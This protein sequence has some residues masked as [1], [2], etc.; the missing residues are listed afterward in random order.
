M[1]WIDRIVASLLES[2]RKRKALDRINSIASFRDS[3]EVRLSEIKLICC[4]L[5]QG[6]EIKGYCGSFNYYDLKMKDKDR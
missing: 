1:N 4:Q 5:A 3:P 6:K 2:D